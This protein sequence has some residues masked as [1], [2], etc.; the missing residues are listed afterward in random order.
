LPRVNPREIAR[1]LSIGRI[2]I[3]VGLIT[4]PRLWAPI[5][6]GRDGLSGAARL[7]SRAVGARDIAIGASTLMAMSK[8]ERIRPW[9]I[10]AIVPDAVDAIATFI[11]R[12]EVPRVSRPL[13]YLMGGG[14]AVAGAAIQASIDQ[15]ND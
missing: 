2:A 15:N 11:E 7:F 13:V 3:G 10:A 12:D 8:G 9:V 6:V 1:A 4:A 14:A 5:W